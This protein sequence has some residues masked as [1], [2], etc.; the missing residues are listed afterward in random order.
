MAAATVTAEVEG[1]A[2]S[3]EWPRLQ[4][5][6]ILLWSPKSL[7]RLRSM[8]TG[9]LRQ[10]LRWGECL[11][12]GH[13][14]Q[15]M[16]VMVTEVLRSQRMNGR[17]TTTVLKAKVEAGFTETKGEDT[18]TETEGLAMKAKRTTTEKTATTLRLWFQSDVEFTG[19]SEHIFT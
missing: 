3:S 8:V 7:E 14:G 11:H 2:T 18:V 12:D 15:I 6:R 16:P 4:K 17:A 10:W 19:L 13:R 9:A 5:S 1:A